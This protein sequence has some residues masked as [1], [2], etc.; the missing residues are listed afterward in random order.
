MKCKIA[1]EQLCCTRDEGRSLGLGLQ[2]QSPNHRK[3]LRHNGR[4]GERY[5]K[6]REKTRQV[7]CGKANVSKP[8]MTYRK[9]LLDVVETRSGLHSWDEAQRK[10]VDWL[11]GNRYLGGAISLTG[12]CAE[13]GNL[14][15]DAK[16]ELRSGETVR[17]TVPM[18]T[19]GADGFVVVRMPGNAGGAKGPDLPAKDGGQPAT[20]G[21]NV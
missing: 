8:L 12:S 4:G 21:A 2:D 11:G 1:F 19:I 10:P 18:R 15:S 14:W 20:G 17:G 5:G 13:R 9:V 3:L 6:R 7:C 16:G